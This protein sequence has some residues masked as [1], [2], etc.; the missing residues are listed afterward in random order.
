ML[1]STESS[2]TLNAYRLIKILHKNNPHIPIRMVINRAKNDYSASKT[3]E[4]L[5]SAV[6]KFLG[7]DTQFLGWVPSDPIVEQAAVERRPFVEKYP[8]SMPARAIVAL[9]TKLLEPPPVPPRAA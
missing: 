4:R 7:S 6:R 2:S 3:A 8:G 1:R 5:N 9:A